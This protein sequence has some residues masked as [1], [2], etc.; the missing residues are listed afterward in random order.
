MSDITLTSGIRQNLLSLQQTSAELTST[1][2]ALATG[3]AVNSAAENP[4]AYFT[5][6]NLTNTANSLS[7][8]LDQIGQGLQTIDAADNGLTGI[9][10]LLQQ[11]LS[12]VQQ[13]QSDSWTTAAAA[14]ST[15]AFGGTSTGSVNLAA[16]A[17]ATGTVN[18]TATTP[19]STTGTVDVTT[20][21]VAA[22]TLTINYGSTSATV[23]ITASESLSDIETAIGSATGGAVTATDD[24]AGH[25]VLGGTSSFTI[26]NN[27]ES[28]T[29]LG[30]TTGSDL[31]V[32]PTLTN[33]ISAGTL[34]IN[35]GAT[36]AAVALTT[37]ESLSNI[38]SAINTA[39]GGVVSATNDGSGH[40]VLSS[41]AGS[42]TISNNAESDTSL[43]LTTSSSGTTTVSPTVSNTAAAGNLVI[44]SGG[45]SYTAAITASESLSDIE[46]AINTATGGVVTATDDGAGHLV[47]SGGSFTVVNTGG[48][49]DTSDSLGLTTG[50][51]N[52]SVTASTT[53]ATNIAAGSLSITVGS[54]T[55]S[56]SVAAGSSLS[57]IEADINNTTGLGSSGAVSATDDGQGHLVLTS[58][59]GPTSFTINGNATSAALG[60]TTSSTASNT[61]IGS[62]T[63]R[64]TLQENYNGL[65]TQINEMAS[66]SGYN[67]VNLLGGDN[68]T[69]DFNQAATSQLVIKGV[70][71]NAQGLGLGSISG[72]GAGSFE[73]NNALT[74]LVS[75]IN[76]AL[77]NV[78]SQTETFG[79]N[80]S[81]ISTRQTFTTAMINTL[82]TGASNLV[83]ADQNEES[84]DLLTE[85]T[86]QQL[87][88]S[89]LSIANQANQSVLKLFS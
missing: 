19:G 36:S 80:S 9:T 75:S 79:T 71:F 51:A 72:T 3:D 85:Q 78:Q 56:V 53:S 63:T 41:T 10:S 68:L 58:T 37:G 87:E 66:D 13:A 34:T 81:T 39:T 24:G 50:S 61:P 88:I 1:Q 57:Q 47:L 26:V 76:T 23:A 16:S 42:F 28:D 17:A 84:A 5:S 64:S 46:S 54:S 86:Q 27:A 62:S 8:L 12:T 82:Q 25:L 30:L 14:T 45:S 73:D 22:G 21:P 32:S 69:I 74:S 70:S 2:Q 31:T 44:T 55:F 38:E 15:V 4:S 29:S 48:T 33:P 40:L 6:Q 20:T 89:A 7:S 83:A 35:Y 52:T 60:L 65:L 77:S 11:A 49:G 43:G 18:L 59:S 67:G